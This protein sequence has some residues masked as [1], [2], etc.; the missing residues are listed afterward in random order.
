M[1][2]KFDWGTGGGTSINVPPIPEPNQ[3]ITTPSAAKPANINAVASPW[4]S[5]GMTTMANFDK[6]KTEGSEAW[7]GSGFQGWYRKAFASILD[8]NFFIKNPTP[9]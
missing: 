3:P 4:L 6:T 8:P 7:Y 9:A 5:Q 2:I 1:P